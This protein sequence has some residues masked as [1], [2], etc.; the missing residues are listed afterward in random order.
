MIG[1]K[2]SSRMT[3]R[4]CHFSNNDR[5][6]ARLIDDPLMIDAG[7]SIGKNRK[8]NHSTSPNMFD[9]FICCV[10][11][12]AVC[13]SAQTT[14]DD[15]RWTTDMETTEPLTTEYEHGHGSV[16][17]ASMTTMPSS[18]TCPPA[19]DAR[20]LE[21]M[22]KDILDQL[23]QA[24]SEKFDSL[25]ER[26][27]GLMESQEKSGST[28][29][30]LNWQIYENLRVPLTGWTLVFDETF[31]HKTRNEDLNQVAGICQNEVLVGATF[32]GTIVLAAVGP[33]TVLR[34]NTN[35][36]QPQQFGQVYW[37][38]TSGK[39]FGFSPTST[40]RQTTADN[41]DLTSSQRL[42][43]LLDQNMGG[44]RVGSV[45]SLHDNSQWRKIIYC[46]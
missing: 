27:S 3:G 46:N 8:S 21:E 18:S 23:L 10:S 1:K 45:R 2:F 9:R 34:Q 15:W 42:S 37:Y 43:W 7:A 5:L 19:I 40:I 4:Y 22:K 6:I 12:I 26:I 13:I 24:I 17:T 20:L 28:P 11:L 35:W 33:A 32:N 25:E 41:E 31:N 36:N 39:S 29:V 16:T 38:K 30:Q 14:D 44:Y